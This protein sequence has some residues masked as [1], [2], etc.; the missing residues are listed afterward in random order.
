MPTMT[1]T[2]LP[3]RQAEGNGRAEPVAEPFGRDGCSKHFMAVTK[4]VQ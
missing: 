1:M 4:P 2:M 3:R